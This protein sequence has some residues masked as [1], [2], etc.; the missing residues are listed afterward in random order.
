MEQNITQYTNMSNKATSPFSKPWSEQALLVQVLV[1]IFL[2][3]NCLMICT[4]F[5]KEAFR[6]DTRYILFAQTL[7]MDS[8]LMV[9]TDLALIGS[10]FQIPVPCIPCVIMCTI[11][12]WLTISTPL[13]LVAMCLERYVAIC[14]P[15]RH[16]SISTTRTRLLGLVLIWC[17]S[18]IP[19]L[20]V[21]FIFTSSVPLS[22]FSTYL[23]CTV[24]MMI[25]HN[26][27]AQ[28]R[29][30][31]FQF[32]FVIMSIAIGF[33]YVKITA[34][35]RAASD[36]KKSASKGLRTVV[37][38]AFQLLLCLIQLLC[39]YVEMAV[40]KIDIKLFINVRYFN[41]V[42][43]M[44]ASRCLSP[45]IYGLRD[46]KFFLVLR[47]YAVFGLNIKDLY[48]CRFCPHYFKHGKTG[49]LGSSIKT[50]G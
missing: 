30:A 44:L 14:M 41:F 4:F 24:E 17:F 32:Y 46:E 18:S 45:L 11:M 40:M 33:T 50:I 23:I 16:A 22:F 25:V 9:F 1:G 26:W 8:A 34:A 28:I 20:I 10:Y 29:A 27:Q 36:N 19:A 7:F 2:Y 47:Y 21:F 42:V 35:A 15:L 43:F 6:T 3:V 13:T 48:L 37:L 38:H 39:P 12:A 31:L 5:K 49:P